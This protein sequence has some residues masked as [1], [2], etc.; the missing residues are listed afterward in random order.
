MEENF[1]NEDYFEE[2][3]PEK[4]WTI[5]I[6]SFKPEKDKLWH[7]IACMSITL[8]TFIV[9]GTF[10]F[11]VL[12]LLI[13][14]AAGYAKELFD[15]YIKHTKFDWKDIAWDTFGACAGLLI[16]AIICIIIL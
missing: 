9:G 5:K 3:D 10:P 2:G 4:K 11:A 12:G 14:L 1:I 16:A 6:D 13:A 8:I 7:F 15:R